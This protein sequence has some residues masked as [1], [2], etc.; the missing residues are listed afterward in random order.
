VNETRI[1][2]QGPG[3]KTAD[4]AI[5]NVLLNYDQH[6]KWRQ[7]CSEGTRKNYLREARAILVRV[8]LNQAINW[9]DLTAD[10]IAQFV[11]ERARALSLVSRQNPATAIRSLLRFLT[12]QGLIRAGL[13]GAI[14]PIW[15]S[16]H[17]TVPRHIA[18][19]K[20][21]TMLALCPANKPHAVRDQAMLLRCARLG[22]RPGEVL[23]LT[24]Q[25]LD[26]NAGCVLLRAGK[27]SQERVLPLPEDVGTALVKYLQ[28]TR[29][30][31]AE[32][33]VFLKHLPPHLPLKNSGIV[34]D[35]V[36]RRLRRAG[37]D[38]SQSG[39]YV[40]RHTLAT[41]MVRK[42]ATFKQVA[43]IL[44]P[45]SLTTTGIYAKLDL[46]TLAQVALPWPGEQR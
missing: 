45:S 8:F 44:G 41:T 12:G 46:P 4:E 7:G 43:D 11:S 22:L 26:W 29:P 13:D 5:E 38:G 17:A 15:R 9:A 39:A 27:T 14:P 28:T 19:E 40:L 6:L 32:R 21:E 23:N 1:G 30:A 34:A 10:Q 3:S 20:V 33:A 24:L 16:Q 37:I 36:N 18:A 42:G 31:S 2:E 25:D 35:V